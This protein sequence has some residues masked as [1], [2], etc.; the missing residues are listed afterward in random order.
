MLLTKLSIVAYILGG[1]FGFYIG[2]GIRNSSYDLVFGT[3]TSIFS[4]NCG[5]SI[6]W[7]STDSSSSSKSDSS[8]SSLLI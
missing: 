4:V 2:S 7:T 5:V 1:V 8:L 3:S 6:W